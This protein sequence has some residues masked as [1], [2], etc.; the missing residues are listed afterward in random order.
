MTASNTTTE[1]DQTC[2]NCGATLT[3]P[4]CARCG[5]NTA[6]LNRPA[7]AL[8]HDSLDSLLSLDG[9]FWT[10][11]V[12]LFRSPG[13]AARDFLD[14]K[15]ASQTQPIRLYLLAALIFV[16][17]FQASGIAFIAIETEYGTTA[18]EGSVEASGLAVVGSGAVD[19]RMTLLRPPWEPAP[20][21]IDW[22]RVRESV[23]QAEGVPVEESSA[24]NQ[25]EAAAIEKGG[26]E[27]FA[28]MAGRDPAG[29]ERAAN[30]ALS[31]A[32]LIMVVIFAAFNAVLHPR[33]PLVTHI[34]HSLYF[35]A[36][37][38][39]LVLGF[40]VPAVFLSS[41]SAAGGI[42]LG[43]LGGVVMIVVAWLSDRRVYA[44]SWYGATLRIVVLVHL[45][46]IAFITL[47]L[48]LVLF[49]VSGL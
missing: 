37:F 41:L 28:A 7:L 34:I 19:V 9:K 6:T 3:G 10:T 21:P 25:T 2:T 39:T 35:H 14:G 44:S 12:G 31:Q 36:T 4:F 18:S 38:L 26:A 33:A 27:A 22:D 30:L 48:T 8:L 17:G 5:Q 29:A 46:I 42:A 23:A 15:R 45:Y 43:A 11:A 47:A 20:E 13:K 1:P 49:A 24:A 32:A 16:L 40:A